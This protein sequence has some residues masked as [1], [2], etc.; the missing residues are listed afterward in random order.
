MKFHL[1]IFAVSAMVLFLCSADATAQT[2]RK[3]HQSGRIEKQPA[4]SL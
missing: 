3:I 1:K 4:E 2:R